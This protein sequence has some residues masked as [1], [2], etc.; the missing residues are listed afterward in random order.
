MKRVAE[1]VREAP[2]GATAW[3]E[4]H[5]WRW[6]PIRT[7]HDGAL[8]AFLS[9]FGETQPTESKNA[10]AA[11]IY[12]E[13]GEMLKEWKRLP[14]S[15]IPTLTVFLTESV[16]LASLEFAGVCAE[17]MRLQAVAGFDAGQC[18][19]ALQ[20]FTG[21]PEIGRACR[22]LQAGFLADRRPASNVSRGTTEGE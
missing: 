22:E 9:L 18:A 13:H 11:A 7:D 15:D 20:G 16:R 17:L 21:D 12:R 3:F 8:A 4:R 14:A 6:H 19:E 1:A 5:L 10:R 2:I